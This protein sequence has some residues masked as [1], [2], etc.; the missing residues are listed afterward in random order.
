MHSKATGKH[1]TSRRQRNTIGT[2][3]ILD[4]PSNMLTFSTELWSLETRSSFLLWMRYRRDLGCTSPCSWS[5]PL[6]L[7][8]VRCPFEGTYFFLPLKYYVVSCSRA[9]ASLTAYTPILP[10]APLIRYGLSLIA[11]GL[12][13]QY[14][15]SVA[16]G[17]RFTVST[18]P[19][20]PTVVFS[21]NPLCSKAAMSRS[22]F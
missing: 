15:P 5:G 7:K 17:V 18:L 1:I 11:L 4:R 6:V 14:P 10:L 9:A 21:S 20:S 16:L 3:C 13:G 12:Q 22:C 19:S 2:F 8:A